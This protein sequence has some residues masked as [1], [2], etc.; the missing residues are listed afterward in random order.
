MQISIGDVQG[1]RAH[2]DNVLHFLKV[3]PVFL[4]GLVEKGMRVII[5]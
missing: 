1:H 3:V 5:H 4:G 2:N